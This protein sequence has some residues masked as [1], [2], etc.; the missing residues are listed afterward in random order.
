MFLTF[1]AWNN[2]SSHSVPITIRQFIDKCVSDGFRLCI[3]VN[4]R[5][6][7][8]A[9]I[10][11][12]RNN[13]RIAWWNCFCR[14]DAAATS[15]LSPEGAIAPQNSLLCARNHQLVPQARSAHLVYLVLTCVHGP[16]QSLTRKSS[17]PKYFVWGDYGIWGSAPNDSLFTGHSGLLSL[18]HCTKSF[19]VKAKTRC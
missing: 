3:A 5:R 11:T 4:G 2:V 8:D 1:C 9:T 18:G 12:H 10:V 13:C 14:L 17:P 16:S 15:H 7:W 6:V 19:E